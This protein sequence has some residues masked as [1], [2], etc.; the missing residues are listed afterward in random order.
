[1]IKD[2]LFGLGNLD[3]SN[4]LNFTDGNTSIYVSKYDSS[5]G[6]YRYKMTVSA[7]CCNDKLKELMKQAKGNKG[8]FRF[9]KAFHQ[10]RFHLASR[11]IPL[12]R[13][14]RPT[15]DVDKRASKGTKSIRMTYYFSD[16]YLA[17]AL[18]LDLSEFYG[19]GT[20]GTKEEI[21]N[22]EEFARR[23]VLSLRDYKMDITQKMK[24]ES[25]G[26]DTKEDQLWKDKYQ[27]QWKKELDKAKSSGLALYVFD[28]VA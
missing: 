14:E 13:M 5:Y 15:I 20:P 27:P 23:K 24:Q 4:I 3:E 9:E 21:I 6:G 12:G 8:V 7:C 16:H 25:C 22:R 2:T 1:M 17:Y 26:D 19:S 28:R 18:G 10:L 11:G